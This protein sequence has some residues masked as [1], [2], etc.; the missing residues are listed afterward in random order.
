MAKRKSE[1]SSE[2]HQPC[3]WDAKLRATP[4]AWKVREMIAGGYTNDAIRERWGMN[5]AYLIRARLPN[6]PDAT[7][8]DVPTAPQGLRRRP[9]E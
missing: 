3:G 6:K 2:D 1:P 5:A 7:P 4:P 8:R 9:A